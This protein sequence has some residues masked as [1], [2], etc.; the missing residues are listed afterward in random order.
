MAAIFTGVAEPVITG[1]SGREDTTNAERFVE[2]HVECVRF[3]CDRQEYLFYDGKRYRLDRE[4]RV[5]ELAKQTAKSLYTV[6][7]GLDEEETI[8][9]GRW[10]EKSLSR[11]RL[12]AMLSL[13]QSDPRIV[14]REERLGC[15]P[16]FSEFRQ[17]HRGPEDRRTTST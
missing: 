10:A 6:A 13:A 4:G 16:L 5:F 1:G 14:V 7:A 11:D 17:R 15:R 3:A 8:R 9:M 12:S 2:Q